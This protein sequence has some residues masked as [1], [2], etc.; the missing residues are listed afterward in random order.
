MERHGMSSAIA[1]TPTSVMRTELEEAGVELLGD[2]QLQTISEYLNVWLEEHR[3]NIGK[4]R[5]VTWFNLFA[6]V[7]QDGSGFITSSELK[8]VL[9][10]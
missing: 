1:S 10:K 8:F 7:D 5:S 3:E 2:E 9:N 6:E 4:E